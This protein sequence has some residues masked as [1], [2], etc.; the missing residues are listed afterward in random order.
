MMGLN[1]AA[2]LIDCISRHQ[3]IASLVVGTPR[4]LRPVPPFANWR[5]GTRRDL[6]VLLVQYARLAIFI[7]IWYFRKYETNI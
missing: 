7:V 2:F 5:N 3:L 6:R 1:S 4:D